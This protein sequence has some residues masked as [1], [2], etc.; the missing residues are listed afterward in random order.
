ME[1]RRFWPQPKALF[2]NN[3]GP[4]LLGLLLMAL[5][6]SL[7]ESKQTG[8]GASLPPDTAII[9]MNIIIIITPCALREDAHALVTAVI[10]SRC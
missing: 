4:R 1:K 7:V 10:A 2:T 5:C 3:L 6:S 8:T 9:G